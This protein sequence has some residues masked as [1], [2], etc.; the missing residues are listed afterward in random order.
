MQE[1]AITCPECGGETV[2]SMLTPFGCVGR[3]DEFAWVTGCAWEDA[4]PE[5][6][7]ALIHEA[8]QTAL[9][10]DDDEAVAEDE[11]QD[12]EDDPQT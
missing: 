12:G 9:G 2:D 10:G 3:F 7:E 6:R 11:E 8:R 4:S 5:M 1:R